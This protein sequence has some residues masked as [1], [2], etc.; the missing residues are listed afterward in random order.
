[1]IPKTETLVSALRILSV[2]IQSG[3]GVAN[4]V[5]AEAADRLTLMANLVAR[6]IEEAKKDTQEMQTACETMN[7]ATETIQRL[8]DRIKRLEEELMDTKNKHAA[9]VADVVLYEDIG[10]RIK[11]LE[12]AGDALCENSNPSRWDSPESAAQKMVDQSNWLE[13][14]EAKP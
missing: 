8:K 13:A 12:E 4:A 10:E 11:R 2:E 1:V 5:V 3:D 14:K 6:H 9:L 7:G